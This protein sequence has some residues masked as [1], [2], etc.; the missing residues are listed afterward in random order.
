MATP[1]DEYYTKM[2]ETLIDHNDRH[3]APF[4]SEKFQQSVRIFMEENEKEERDVEHNVN[5]VTMDNFFNN[6]TISPSQGDIA[7]MKSVHS[8][9]SPLQGE[10][11][12]VTSVHSTIL[13]SQ[14]YTNVKNERRIASD[15]LK[16]TIKEFHG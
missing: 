2:L 15:I 14:E 13:P 7:N 12:N 8:N 1:R 10:I 3:N 4:Y 6:Y 9:I 5:N 11:E 16:K